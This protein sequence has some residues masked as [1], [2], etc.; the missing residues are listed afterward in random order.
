MA[1]PLP[2]PNPTALRIPMWADHHRVED[3][4]NVHC[5]NYTQCIDTAVRE[6]WDG[7]SCQKCPLFKQDSSPGADRLAFNQP[8]DFDW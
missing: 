1:C 5:R 8:A 3:Y 4:R 7:F 6:N 2:K